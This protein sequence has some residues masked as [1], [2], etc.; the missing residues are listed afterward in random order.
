MSVVLFKV[1][2]APGHETIGVKAC[3]AVTLTKTRLGPGRAGV[4]VLQEALHAI[5]RGVGESLHSQLIGKLAGKESA[6]L[7]VIELVIELW[8][9]FWQVV[10]IGGVL[11]S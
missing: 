4:C 8:M 10:F 9:S 2:G 1:L 5:A 7:N 3:V 11:R 6:G